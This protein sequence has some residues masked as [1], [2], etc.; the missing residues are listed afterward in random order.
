[1]SA[2]WKKPEKNKAI[3]RVERDLTLLALEDAKASK[4]FYDTA[5]TLES[6]R[7]SSN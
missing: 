5:H 4:H 6:W 3:R 7:D 1:M 2:K